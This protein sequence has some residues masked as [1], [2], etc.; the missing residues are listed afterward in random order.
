VENL[1]DSALPHVTI[2]PQAL[3]GPGDSRIELSDIELYKNW[4]AR[5]GSHQ[6]QPAYNIPM[7]AGDPFTIPDEQRDI[8]TQRNQT[9]YV[10]VYIP[11]NAKP[12]L[13]QGAITVGVAGAASIRLPMSLEVYNFAL[14]DRLSFW[15]ELNSYHVPH[16][17]PHAYFR[18]AHQHRCVFM[19]W[20]MRSA[21]S[22]RGQNLQL[23]FTRYD[24]LAG[25]LLSGAAFQG[26]RRR[27]VPVET[28]YLPFEDSWPTPLS[29]DT[30][31]Y[32]G[33]WPKRGDPLDS[34]TQHYLTAPYIGDAL[35][36]VYKDGIHAAQKQFID[37][38][39]EKG[40]TYTEMHAF[41]G[42]KNT[43]RI[44]YG[45]NIWWTTDEPYHWDDWLALQ[46]FLR[47]WQV[48]LQHNLGANP[49]QWLGR[50]DISRPQWQGRVL[51]HL[52]GA[53]YFGTGALLQS[54]RCR[55]LAQE[56][57]FDLRS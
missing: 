4:Y 17:Q 55:M 34:I 8:K 35:S 51:D 26:N 13:Y 40:W 44:E 15:P 32:Q 33:Y 39:R 48:G 1:G 3:K 18:L 20:V 41:Y 52:V 6:W 10:D 49:K 12:G 46:F 19:P 37:H 21:V 47:H 9:I 27:G 2:V 22:G 38:F 16:R 53:V 14:P 30:Y 29:K 43:H 56:T 31:N 28:M 57:G 25:L 7:R 50:A 24:Q 11:G 45:A 54:R 36:Q 42:G 23:D 5:N